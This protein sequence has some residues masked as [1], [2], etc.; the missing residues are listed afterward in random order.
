VIVVGL[1]HK[2][3]PIDVRERLAFSSEQAEALLAELVQQPSV[4]EALVVSTCNRVE[5]VAAGA[6][7]LSV[8]ESEVARVVREVLGS[9]APGVY[10]HLYSHLGDQAVR[11]LFRVASSLDSLVMG[12]PQILGQVKSAYE[13]AR[14][15]GT[16]GAQLNRAVA[17]ALRTAKRVRTETAL[18]AGQVSVPSVAVDLA[19]Q[20][21][22]DLRDHRALLIGSGQMGEAAA[23][24][25]VAAGAHLGVMG[26]NRDRVAELAA[27][28]HGEP[29]GFE[30]LS[31]ELSRV[32]VIVT[33]TSSPTHIVTR[34]QVAQV[35]RKRRG[36]SLFLI[37]LAVPRDVDP[38][39][40]DLDAVFLYNVDD[41][42]QIVADTLST[43]QRE[44]ESAEQIVEGEAR[45]YERAISAEQATPTIVTLRQQFG[46]ILEAELERSLRGRLKH[47]GD[48]E[49]D[50]L[51]KMA[52]SA[53]NKLLHP[54]TRHLRRLATAEDAEVELDA[55]VAV[56]RDVFALPSDS[57]T[58]TSFAPT[59]SDGVADGVEVGAIGDKVG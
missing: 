32:D 20:I 46:R 5:I 30:D 38:T 26:R 31:D 9:R 40:G 43:R 42:S 17:H 2:T 54:A 8:S 14:R 7:T 23:K 29:H 59:C 36:K 55:T 3:A 24:L 45:S 41:L 47:L 34:E 52:D 48:E 28:M 27:R 35:R 49:R 37:D 1:S 33:T 10:P 58:R 11:H 4:S 51:Q 53:L 57:V 50:A 44:A 56:L 6:R 21:F 19:R 25:L 18:G 16:I 22:G 39:V 12:E 15:Q 13:A